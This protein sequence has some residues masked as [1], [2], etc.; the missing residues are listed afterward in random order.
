MK[1]YFGCFED[2]EQMLDE[3]GRITQQP[4]PTED[5]VLFASYGAKNFAGDAIVIFEHDGKLYEANGGHCSCYGLG[6]SDYSGGKVSQWKPEETSWAA[7]AIRQLD[8]DQHSHEAIAAFTSLVQ[9]RL[10]GE[11]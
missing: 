7:L 9:S 6:E 11:A 4:I 10:V 5:E 2:F 1:K 3:W 8:A